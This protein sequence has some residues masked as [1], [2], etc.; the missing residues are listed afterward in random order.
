MEPNHNRTH[1]RAQTPNQGRTF[2]SNANTER[3]LPFIIAS[4]YRSSL[5][6]LAFS[7]STHASG[8]LHTRLPLHGSQSG[9]H[10]SHKICSSIENLRTEKKEIQIKR[11]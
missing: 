1:T 7:F 6:P 8:L 4:I 5:D 9:A 3:S 2:D 10:L 11:R